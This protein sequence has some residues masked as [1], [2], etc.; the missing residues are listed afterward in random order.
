MAKRKPVMVGRRRSSQG[1]NIRMD[2]GKVEGGWR[3]E[4]TAFSSIDFG[5]EC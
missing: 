1:N 3:M 2:L 5:K 4:Q